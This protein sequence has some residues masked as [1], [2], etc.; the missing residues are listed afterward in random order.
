MIAGLTGA[1][2]NFAWFGGMAASIR[3]FELLC[4]TCLDRVPDDAPVQVK[5]KDRALRFVHWS[6]R[7]IGLVGI[8]VLVTVIAADLVDALAWLAVPLWA[9][10]VFD[11][12]A[13]QFHARVVPWCPYCRGGGG[14]PREASPTP[15]PVGVKTA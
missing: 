12:W 13:V 4:T 1:A 15:D 5:R 14:G 2:C 8:G 7:R 11:E 3:H 10:F 6:R 9:L